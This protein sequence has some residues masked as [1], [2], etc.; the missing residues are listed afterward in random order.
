MN[1]YS[2][3]GTIIIIIIIVVAIVNKYSAS[4]ERPASKKAQFFYARKE[5]LMTASE[6]EFFRI[7]SEIAGDRYYIFPQIHLSALFT[8]KTYGRFSKLGGSRINQWSVDYVL[9]DR[10]TLKPIYAVELDD[11]THNKPT[12]Q[13]RD[14]K[15][16]QIFKDMNMPLVRFRDYRNLTKDQISQ[17]FADVADINKSNSIKAIDHV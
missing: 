4:T 6:N 11:P 1:I 2:I 10:T 8:N 17:R 7:L 12:R 14:A 13:A 16:E 15:V 9:C 3:A 5:Y